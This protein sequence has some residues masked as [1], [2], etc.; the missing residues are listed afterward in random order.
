MYALILIPLAWTD[1]IGHP[2]NRLWGVDKLVVGTIVGSAGFWL[3][4]WLDRKVRETRGK[5][6]FNY[7][8]IILPVS[9]LVIFSIIMYLVTK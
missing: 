6:L 3:A 9:F 7:Q 2:F 8:K 1:I 4:V 5:Q